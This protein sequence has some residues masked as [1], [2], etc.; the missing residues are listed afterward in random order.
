MPSLFRR[1]MLLG[2]PLALAVTM[3]AQVPQ[4]GW[5]TYYA[6][7]ATFQTCPWFEG[8]TDRTGVF[9]FISHVFEA[10]RYSANVQGDALLAFNSMI[11]SE[12]YDCQNYSGTGLVSQLVWGNSYTRESAMQLR[13]QLI[14]YARTNGFGVVEYDYSDDDK[15]AG[16]PGITLWPT[17]ASQPPRKRGQPAGQGQPPSGGSGRAGQQ[18][19]PLGQGQPPSGATWAAGQQQPPLT[20]ENLSGVPSV[21]AGA[22][23]DDPWITQAYREINMPMRGGGSSGDCN[24]GLYG[25]AIWG[26][27]SDPYST[28]KTWV[29]NSKICSDPWIGEAYATEI[30][31]RVNGSGTSGECNIYLYGGGKWSGFPDLA[32]KIKAY[33][34]MRDRR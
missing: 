18:Q 8:L 25:G 10:K 30:G 17:V 7:Y 1:P 31:R 28:L 9:V 23:C 3:A 16:W 24:I 32:S 20:P 22:R 2:V 27:Y 12:G 6:Y 19:P 14:S 13:N 21:N 34:Q 11:K 29:V 26:T 33:L 15:K 5:T 4:Q